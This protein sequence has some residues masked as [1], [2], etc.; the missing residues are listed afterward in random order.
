MTTFK[1]HATTPLTEAGAENF[2]D[3]RYQHAVTPWDRGQTSPALL[4]WLADRTLKPCR[5]L[6]PG[7]GRGYEVVELARRGFDVVALDISAAAIQF[8]QNEL[9]VHGLEAELIQS[10]LF[11]WMPDRPFTAVYEQ[12]C[13]CALLPEQWAAYT[14]RLVEW[15]QPEGDLFA[16]FMQTGK[17]NGPPFHCDIGRMQQ[18]FAPPTWRWPTGPLP[19]IDHPAGVFEFGAVLKRC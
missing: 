4:G 1:W 3:L 12:T 7:C 9:N 16:L 10:D 11:D 15:I 5:I 14:H 19:R 18:L 8:V 13:L 17:A 2:W 6:L